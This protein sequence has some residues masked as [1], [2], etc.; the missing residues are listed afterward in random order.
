[1]SHVS[2]QTPRLPII[3]PLPFTLHTLVLSIDLAFFIS[4]FLAP[5]LLQPS[6]TSLDLHFDAS[7]PLPPLG[8]LLSDLP[9]HLPHLSSLQIVGVTRTALRLIQ[10]F[11]E[12]EHLEW[13]DE[14]DAQGIPNIKSVKWVTATGG[15]ELATRTVALLR[16]TKVGESKLA[17]LELPRISGSER[18]LGWCRELREECGRRGIE[19][20]LGRKG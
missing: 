20:L 3:A 10:Q 14:W 4:L 5:A 15:E 17:K 8:L 11:S 13:W 9:S 19:L 6:I 16:R 2:F 18:G 7:N 12:L 1:M